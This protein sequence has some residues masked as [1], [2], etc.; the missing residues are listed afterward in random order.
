MSLF[1]MPGPGLVKAVSSGTPFWA[2]V[3]AGSGVAA[4]THAY[5]VA[6]RPSIVRR[7]LLAVAASAT[8]ITFLLALH[9]SLSPV[10]LHAP[11]HHCIFCVMQA[12]LDVQLSIALVICG[13]WFAL[14]AG[15]L[16]SR[17]QKRAYRTTLMRLLG[18]A[19]AMLGGGMLVLAFR[20]AFELIR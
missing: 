2:W 14:V 17:V 9:S 8:V 19:V 4:L 16:P 13:A 7:V 20:T 10:L 11:F 1:D 5:L 18:A 15:I 6:H 3:F 12:S